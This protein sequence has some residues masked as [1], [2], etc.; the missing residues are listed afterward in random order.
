MVAP[1]NCRRP[2]FFIAGMWRAGTTSLWQYLRKHPDIYLSDVKEPHHFYQDIPTE[3][4][5][6][7][8]AEHWKSKEI[9]ILLQ[10][11]LQMPFFDI[12]ST[13][14]R[15]SIRNGIKPENMTEKILKYITDNGLYRETE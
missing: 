2:N 12:S 9:G 5:D 13:A 4:L 7:E 14:V 11:V 15:E 1:E 10:S 8:L 6:K 3:K